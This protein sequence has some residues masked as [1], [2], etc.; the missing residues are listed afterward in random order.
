[1]S[2]ITALFDGWAWRMAWRDSR[3]GRRRL[4]LYAASM[5]VGVAAL[6]AIGSYGNNMRR[7]VAS[8]A[9]TMVGADLRISG[10][11]A[12]EPEVEAFLAAKVTEPHQ[13]ERADSVSFTSM[14]AFP[15]GDEV[16]LAQV[17]AVEAGFPFYGEVITD[18]PGGRALLHDA[19]ASLPYALADPALL[20]QLGAE[21]GDVLTV[22]SREYLVAASLISV[23]GESARLALF[24]P[25]IYLPRA[26]LDPDLLARGSR[27]RH[28][29]MFRLSNAAAVDLDALR[30]E[31]NAELRPRRMGAST[32]QSTGEGWAESIDRMSGFLSL[33]SFVALL[34]GGL[35]VGS[36]MHV[37]ARSKLDA[38]ATLRCLGAPA[39]RAFA[40]YLVQATALGLLVALMGALA[41][42]G[43]QQLLPAVLADLLPVDVAVSVEGR[44]V[45]MGAGVGFVVALLFALLPLLAVRRVPPLR[46]LRRAEQA[47]GRDR[48]VAVL[49]GGLVLAVFGFAWMQT[50]SWIVGLGFVLGVGIAY[51][52]LILLATVV[53]GLL[54]RTVPRG[55]PYTWRQ[56]LANLYRPHNQTRLLMVTLGL[57]TFLV[58]TLH[59]T[60]EA[61]LQQVEFSDRNDR[62][63]V[64]MFDIQSD[65]KQGLT[66]LVKSLGL[67]IRQD[68]PMVNMRLAS[69]RGV[70]T[71]DMR[72]ADE[73]GRPRWALRREFRTT[74]RD[75]IT[76]TETVVGGTF[77]EAAWDGNGPVPVSVEVGMAEELGVRLGDELVWNVQG[78]VIPSVVGSLREVDWRR[79]Q[80]NFFVVFPPGVLED[81]PQFHVLVTRADTPQAIGDLQRAVVGAYPNVSLI[82]VTL[83]LSIADAI[84]DRIAF[85]IRFMAL[86]C[87]VAGVLVLFAAVVVT[88]TQRIEESVLLRT[89]GAVKSQVLTIMNVEYVMLGALATITGALLSLG[90]AWAL[91]RFVL[92]TEFVAS[93]WP[94][95]VT[96]VTVC[97]LTWLVGRLHSRGIH[98]RPPLEILRA[99]G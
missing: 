95:L 55:L 79:V 36:S 17:R 59:L 42:L 27:V 99:E 71:E 92:D 61:L 52:V 7:A 56:G 67:P 47:S 88:R 83:I 12:F 21:R 91:T 19:G 66:E 6:V 40:V 43:V 14:V 51:G 96:L 94:L 2:W 84:L 5:T 57:V 1:M 86:F 44:A 16:R 69:V 37:Y 64:V 22:G 32:S 20:A 31:L 81:A 15:H 35:G 70:A 73:N 9:K 65:Q 13:A 30:D 10:R 63:N 26:S 97:G 8:Q 72:N 18:P 46:A 85:V 34:L 78:V 33:V 4:V 76:D 45:A 62:P 49:I 28:Q 54:R 11:H 23:P 53:S 58:L 89:L 50:E 74:Y 39:S 41:G 60:E 25:R 98:T 68:V 93:P 80:T 38:V 75:H 90:A 29:A 24:G 48:L 77:L 82:D 3:H 87:I